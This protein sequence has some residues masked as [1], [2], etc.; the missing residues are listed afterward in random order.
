MT[1][2]TSPRTRA[3]IET[4]HPITRDQVSDD[5]QTHIDLTQLEL[6]REVACQIADLNHNL[7]KLT[8][9]VDQIREQMCG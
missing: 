5:W 9:S 7:A 6:L 2:N 3:Q 8:V 1:L 4:N